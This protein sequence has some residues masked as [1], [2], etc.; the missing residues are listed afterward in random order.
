M[1]D[2]I[3]LMQIYRNYLEITGDLVSLL[4]RHCEK[5]QN[6]NLSD[7][8]KNKYMEFRNH[9]HNLIE[10]INDDLHK[11][12]RIDSELKEIERLENEKT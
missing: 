11:L 3:A 1:K 8:M 5:V 2:S 9:A 12:I 6:N 7:T 4:E 10:N